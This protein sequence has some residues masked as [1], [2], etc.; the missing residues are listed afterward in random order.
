MI[1]DLVHTLNVIFV[2]CSNFY[3]HA[4]DQNTYEEKIFYNIIDFYR[5][6]FMYSKYHAEIMQTDFVDRHRILEIIVLKI[7]IY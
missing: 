4:L 6:H 3:F 5:K 7:T 1:Y 2:Q